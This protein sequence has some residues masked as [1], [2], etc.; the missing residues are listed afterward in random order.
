MDRLQKAICLVALR[1][2]NTVRALCRLCWFAPALVLL[3]SC[4]TDGD[5]LRVFQK[6][7]NAAAV[8]SV[9]NPNIW[10]A[11]VK[12]NLAKKRAQRTP[13][14]TLDRPVWHPDPSY[15]ELALASTSIASEGVIVAQLNDISIGGLKPH[16][17]Y[18]GM[19]ASSDGHITCSLELFRD[20]NGDAV[21]L[22]DA[23]SVKLES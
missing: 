13:L 1:M 23:S 19:V 14:V 16:Q 22:Y 17:D 4:S 9:K 11:L 2:L 20:E 8:F 10:N 12:Q 18:D 7:C 21:L 15:P 3:N 5:A 6:R